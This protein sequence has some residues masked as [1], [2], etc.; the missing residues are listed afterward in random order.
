MGRRWLEGGRGA[1]KEVRL[2]GRA[3]RRLRSRPP[4]ISMDSRHESQGGRTGMLK[5]SRAVGVAEIRRRTIGLVGGVSGVAHGGVISCRAA[6][7][8][9]DER[10]CEAAV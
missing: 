1:A 7:P 6:P 2:A 4:S 9:L 8:V 10:L 3:E 5:R